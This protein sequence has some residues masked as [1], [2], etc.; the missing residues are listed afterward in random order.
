MRRYVGDALRAR[1][2]K[3]DVGCVRALAGL[4]GGSARWVRRSWRC[5]RAAP[6][7]AATAAAYPAAA[8]LHALHAAIHVVDDLI[9]GEERPWWSWRPGCAPTSRWRCSPSR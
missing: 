4:A 8:S 1:A 3:Y 9:D 6:P 2:D 7:A 5:G